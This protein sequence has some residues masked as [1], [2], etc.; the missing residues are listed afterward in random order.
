MRILVVD[1]DQLL[2]VALAAYLREE[3]FGISSS[4]L[5]IISMFKLADAVSAVETPPWPDLVLLDLNLD[6]D[7]RGTNTFRKFQEKNVYNIPVV[8]YTGL[9]L[10]ADESV[11]ILRECLVTSR[12]KARGIILKGADLDRAFVGLKQLA[13]GDEWWPNEV[14]SKLVG[15]PPKKRAELT[16]SEMAV[17]YHLV[18]GLGNKEFAEAVG[19][20]PESIQQ[21]IGPL[22]RKLGV[23]KRS[24]AVRVLIEGGYLKNYVFSPKTP[25]AKPPEPQFPGTYPSA[26]SSAA[27]VLSTDAR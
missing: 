2:N 12:N 26:E 27:P 21:V 10:D 11:D 3:H 16:N 14:R 17:A 13:G 19:M 5:N 9:D 22:L 6:G 24:G 7:N 4:E 15:E 25:K 8:L 1:N 23:K 18:K 20:T